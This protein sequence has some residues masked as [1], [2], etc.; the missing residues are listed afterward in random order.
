MTDFSLR[1]SLTT[2]LLL[3]LAACPKGA[4]G[5][6][7][8]SLGT[9][10]D[11]S[12]NDSLTGPDSADTT[13]GENGICL[14]HNCESD[15]D[16][17][18]CTEGR[19]SCYGPDKRCVACNPDTGDGCADGEECTEFGYCVPAGAQCPAD[20]G[21]QCNDDPD[22]APC[23]P[24]HQVCSA[25][26]CVECRGDMAEACNGAETCVDEVCVPKCPEECSVDADCALCGEGTMAPAMACHN[27]RCAEC[28][29][30]HPCPEGESCTPEGR[31]AAICGLPGMVVGVCDADAHCTGCDGDNDSCNTPINGGHGTCGPSASG[32]S[33]LG[34]GVV[35]LP[36][37][38]DQVTNLCSNDDDCSNISIDYN[39]GKLLRDLTGLEAIGDAVIQ[40]SMHA[41]A[42]VTVGT[43]GGSISCGVC[44]PCKED[45]DCTDIDVDDVAGDAFGPLGAIGAALLLDQLFGANDHLIHM[46]CQ[47]VAGDYGVCVPCPTLLNDCTGGGGGGGGGS[48]DHDVCTAGGPLTPECGSCAATICNLDDFCCSNSWDDVCV[49]H[50]EENCA[51]GCGG[52]GG[53]NCHDQC[54]AGAAMN[55]SCSA[56]VSSICA[57]D[58]FCCQTSWDDTCVSE[59]DT[60]CDGQCAGTGCSH[61]ECEQ[62]G[63]LADGCSSCVTDV[64]DADPF[65]CNTDWDATCAGEADS[66]CGLCAGGGCA[67]DECQVGGPLDEACSGC[68][69]AVCG[70]DSFCCTNQWDSMCVSEAEAS[71]SCP[72]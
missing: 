53:G 16:C 4:E 46:F 70:E 6:G 31:C 62:G 59:V 24:D 18:G 9:I 3:L 7:S 2:S 50:V 66:I 68:A 5:T 23:D 64:C 33:D 49:G 63:P 47:P 8:A 11:S 10:G 13:A 12:G 61:S 25:G 69:G 57:A 43:G 51:G 20:V 56:C 1:A 28:S 38:F 32:C 42:S 44:V 58:P 35:V 37:P 52:G 60:F 22:C 34:N 72:C 30:T 55:A 45:D 39:V 17:E 71:A 21:T 40:Y 27:H 36:E 29:D 48:C 67:H 19:N 14:L 15:F 65:C 41:C 26:A 54:E